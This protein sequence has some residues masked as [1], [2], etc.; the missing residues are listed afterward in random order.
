MHGIGQAK[1]NSLITHY[2]AAGVE[3]RVHKLTR[4][5]PHNALQYSETRMVV[6]FIVNYTDVPGRTPY[7]WKDNVRLLPTNCT[8]KV[9]YDQYKTAAVSAQIRAVAYGTFRRIWQEA[10][11]FIVTMRPATDLCWVCQQGAARLART[12]NLSDECKSESLQAIQD[13]LLQV[14]K[15]RSLYRTVCK[16]VQN[17]LGPDVHLG[18]NGA[19]T[20]E[21]KCHY[22]FVQ[23]PAN[24]LQPGPIFFKSPRKCGM[25]GVCC[26]ALP[27]QLN[28]LIDEAVDVGKGANCVVSLLHH[29]FEN[30]GLGETEVHLHADNCSG[31]NKNSC[32]MM[33]LMW[34]VLTGRH[35][36]I[37]LSFM[38]TG[39]TKFSCDWCFG[40]VKRLYRRTPVNCLGDLE[41]VVTKSSEGNRA[42]L[43]GDEKGS[44]YVVSYDWTKF[45]A[46]FFRKVKQ[47]KKYHHFIFTE[48]SGTLEVK[49]FSD[50]TS[51]EQI[52][53]VKEP[54]MHVMP[55]PIAPKGLD[56]KSQWYLFEEI[57]DFVLAD[58][59]TKDLV[60]PKPSLPKPARVQTTQRDGDSS[61]EDTDATPAPAKRGRQQ[62]G[63]VRGS[64]RGKGKGR[65]K[66][67]SL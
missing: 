67:S 62:G 6:D 20:F 64:T 10:L 18:Q 23:Y 22:S 32:M 39:H 14:S 4:R 12:V 45:L 57:R 34:R 19:C 24:P 11:P 50:S 29:F 58:E 56:L 52:L 54:S 60:A 43:C 53:L 66:K 41:S 9:V 16:E 1:L 40:L 44:V 7:H 61:D 28:Y 65:G 30:F 27:S 55:E 25:F 33:Y 59:E 13:H 47:I 36:K 5:R 49:E 46:N 2:K 63:R 31:Q 51:Q 8:K 37:T 17:S 26:E 15:E 21:G 3:A 35:K 48:G 38:I 42:Q